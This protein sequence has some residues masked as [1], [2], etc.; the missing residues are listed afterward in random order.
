MF[1]RERNTHMQL[2]SPNPSSKPPRL[3]RR[4]GLSAFVALFACAAMVL[5]GCGSSKT[6]SSS[7]TTAGGGG[8]SATTASGGS[9]VVAQ[10][11]ATLAKD[12]IQPTQL[13]ITTP[14]T[15]PIPKGKNVVFINCGEA[16]C[17]QE[18]AIIK[19]ATDYLHWNLQ[20]INTDGSAS[21]VQNAW[22]QILREKPFGV[23][24]TAFPESEF[25]SSLTTAVKEGI[26]TA[27]CCVTDPVGNGLDWIINTASG[28]GSEAEGGVFAQW[29]VANSSGPPNTLYVNLP[30]FPILTAAY[31]ELQSAFKSLAPTGHLYTVDIPTADIGASAG[32]QLVT[33]FLRSHP[34]VTEVISSTDGLSIGLPSA[35][36]AAGVTGIKIF[37]EGATSTNLEYIKSGL[38]AGSIAFDYY[39]DMFG[40]VDALARISVGQKLIDWSPPLWILNSSNIP[41]VNALFPVVKDSPQ[42]FEALWK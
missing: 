21:Q 24:Y 18:G 31:A 38:Q 4:T 13:P 14:I 34:K 27:A 1:K 17:T 33:S 5:V 15:K 16:S 37:G 12:S 11:Q 29:A 36:K 19:Q 22:A 28:V 40:M 35:L 42:K 23:M 32:T 39:E 26:H 25:K 6:S 30:Q 7:A 41:T 9:S 20:V 8:S 2:A 3:R 10:A